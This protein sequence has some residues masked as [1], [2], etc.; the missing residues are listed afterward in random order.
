MYLMLFY[1]DVREYIWENI[2][3]LLYASLDHDE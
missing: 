2:V 3:A 1:F